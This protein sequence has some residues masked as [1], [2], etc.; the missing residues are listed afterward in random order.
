M[1]PSDAKKRVR[2]AWVRWLI[3]PLL[4]S[5]ATVALIA[6]TD[7]QEMEIAIAVTFEHLADDLLLVDA[8]RHSIRVLVSGSPSALKSID[9][10]QIF[11]RLDLSGL[12][13][14]THSLSVL[15]TDVVLTKGISLKALLTPSLTIGLAK[16]SQKTV[17]VFAVLEGAP[18]PGFAVT[19]VTL[20]PERIVLKGTSAML[21]GI[22]TVKTRPIDLEGASESFKKEA[23]LNLPEVIAVAPPLRIVVA[24]VEIGERIVTRVL[25]NVPVS[26]KGTSMEYRIDPHAITLTVS[27]P[28]AT[29]NTIET[30]PSF[31]VAVD[32]SGLTPGTYSLT[33]VI[34]LPV[35]TTLVRVTPERFSVTIIHYRR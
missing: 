33:A 8:P 15:P 4:L 22:D 17:E 11:C 24:E 32:L 2:G 27:G 18:A 1:K 10:A 23:P 30:H 25:E 7:K 28:E 3:V 14:G 9:P 21:V 19:R 5:G 13:E 29:V 26:V 20:K 6:R 31:A 16:M 34:N 12:G 35:R